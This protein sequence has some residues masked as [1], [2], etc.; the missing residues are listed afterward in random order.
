[1]PFG[2]VPIPRVFWALT[3]LIGHPVIHSHGVQY[4]D[5]LTGTKTLWSTILW[6]RPTVYGYRKPFQVGRHRVATRLNLV[7]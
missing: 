7:T 5:G 2:D 1:V 6:F 3:E 4:P